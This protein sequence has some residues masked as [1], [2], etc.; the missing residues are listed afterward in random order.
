MCAGWFKLPTWS[1]SSESR[2]NE[3]GTDAWRAFPSDAAFIQIDVDGNEIGRNYEPASG[4]WAM[5][6]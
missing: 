6:V 1:C 3:N 4:C 2:T 5:P